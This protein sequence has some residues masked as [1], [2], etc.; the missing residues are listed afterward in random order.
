MCE[1]G[2]KRETKEEGEKEGREKVI[3]ESKV[4]RFAQIFTCSRLICNANEANLA[5]ITSARGC[6]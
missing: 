6:N 2:A 1:E 5:R 4:G 3:K